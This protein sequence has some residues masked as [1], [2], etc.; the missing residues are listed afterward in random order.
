MI[1]RSNEI[2]VFVDSAL[3]NSTSIS[4]KD[5]MVSLDVTKQ[6]ILTALYSKGGYCITGALTKYGVISKLKK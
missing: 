1:D 6:Q 5:V 4:T 2:V 3:A